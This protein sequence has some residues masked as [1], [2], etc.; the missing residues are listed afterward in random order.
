V[1][2]RSTRKPSLASLSR[3]VGP[4]SLFKAPDNSLVVI[5]FDP[6]FGFAGEHML[7]L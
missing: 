1:L 4:T 6:R 7:S 2:L 5:K 3:A